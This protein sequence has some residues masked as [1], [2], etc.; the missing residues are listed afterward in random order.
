MKVLLSG[1][2]AVAR[3]AWEE[4]VVVATAYPGTPSTEILEAL[5]TL[6]GVHA[7]WSPNEKVAL[8]VGIGASMAGVRVLVAMKHVGLNVAAD[9]FMT[10]S[11]TGVRGGLVVV[12]ADD[13]AL[14]SSQNEQDNRH[15]ARM[16][17]VPMLEPVDSR[18]CKELMEEAYHISETF[19]TPVLFRITTRI[20]HGKGV[21]E[22]GR[23]RE[24]SSKG[25]ELDPAKWV[26]LPNF[27][28]DRHPIVE[29]RMER[30]VSYGESFPGN[31]MELR[32]PDLGFITSGV[33][34]QYV[35]EAF[36]R[37]SVLKLTLTYPLPR[38]RV[39]DF[40]GRVKRL[41]VV[42]E[43]DPFLEE[44]IRALG[45]EVVGKQVF[46]RVGELSP[47]LVKKGVEKGYKPSFVAFPDIPQRPPSLCPGCPHRGVFVVL[48]KLKVTVFGDIGCYTL[49]ALPP[50]SR[51]HSCICMGAGVGMVHGAEKAG[52]SGR[53][54]AVIGDSTFYHS[55]IT[56]LADIVYNRGASTVVIMDNG[57]TAMTGKQGHPGT[58][59]A[60]QGE[61][62]RI[63][64]E[65]LVK[66]LGVDR[67]RVVDP[68]DLK[69]MEE[70]F[71][72]E[73]E[74]PEPSVI[75]TRR[76]C[77]LITPG[78]IGFFSVDEDLCIGCGVCVK[79]GCIALSMVGEGEE[80]KARIDRHLC[81]GCGVCAQVCPKGAIGEDEGVS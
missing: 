54:V 65:S 72:E 74:S 24:V 19:D 11:Y 36:P 75:I 13:P 66:G 59:V 57:T 35:R 67:V 30:L 26:M 12:S 71:R 49:G 56:G 53:M 40:A 58:G 17:K 60:L 42:E 9:P 16:A 78:P 25:M 2:E 50:L 38:A 18:E 77:T 20:A 55:G 62:K 48:K 51:L 45:I 37:A 29:E 31:R 76:P 69:A 23:R 47:E 43:L 52:S 21:V 22:L 34:Y 68:Y 44:Q 80:R 32:E 15:Y 33:A 27:A 61:G 73:T 70:V 1:D 10:L 14:Y 41:F 7:Q 63:H 39:L 3:G 6:P 5:A 64:L 4:G 81:Y 28:R 79:V 46:P 8:E